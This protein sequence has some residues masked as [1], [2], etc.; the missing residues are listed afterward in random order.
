MN[1]I[2]KNAV[3]RPIPV[4]A[5]GSADDVTDYKEAKKAITNMK[6]EKQYM[7]ILLK[8][9][10]EDYGIT[11]VKLCQ[12]VNY[13]HKNAYK[14]LSESA[15][16]QILNWDTWP[17][18]CKPELIRDLIEASLVQKGVPK[19]A[20]IRLWDTDIDGAH[21]PVR[22]KKN[23]RSIARTIQLP[24]N[25]MLSENAKKHFRLNKDPFVNDIH[26]YKDVFLSADQRY[27]SESMYQTAKHGG[28][29]AVVGECGAGKTTLRR[30]L[31]ERIE[32]E[33]LNVTVI[34]PRIIDKARLS[35]GAICEAI[36][37]DISSEKPRSSLEHKAR[38][39][40]RLLKGSSRAGNV[41]VL[42]IEEA[43]DMS[44]TTLKYL[45][46][47]W[48]LEDGHKK[49]LSIILVGQLELKNTLDEKQNWEAREVIRR[50]EVAELL[51]LNNDLEK[52]LDLKFERVGR[53]LTDI[54]EDDAYSA[55]R[56]RLSLRNRGHEHAVN[57]MFPLV[58][59]N[60]VTK[61]MNLAADIGLPKINADLIKEV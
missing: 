31:L 37:E 6:G 22:Y 47:F 46:R 36:I 41:H 42:I 7:P 3:E 29:L 34:Q 13:T 24:E 60:A 30:D 28:F 2:A 39:I 38:Q 43:H 18:N 12:S 35:A 54:F 11:Q 55:I 45:K 33:N 61:A 17:K 8:Q 53:S 44:V 21:K 58:V 25:Q 5:H 19:L 49:L 20:L 9:V 4:N 51:P 14:K 15:L 23:K 48:E 32:R 40:E 10:L 52:Y 1:T 57:M 27:I 59:N 56:E 50:C 26:S 16:N